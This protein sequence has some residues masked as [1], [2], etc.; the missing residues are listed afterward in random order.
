[1]KTLGYFLLYWPLLAL[2]L[3]LW[4]VQVWLAL[5]I[6]IAAGSIVLGHRL[7]KS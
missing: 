1:M 6:V 2:G 4:M 5:M 3:T 7:V